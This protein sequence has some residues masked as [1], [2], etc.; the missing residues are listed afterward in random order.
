MIVYFHLILNIL[1]LDK[2]LIDN[3]DLDDYSLPFSLS[4]EKELDTVSD[5]IEYK[6]KL[7]RY[8]NRYSIFSKDKMF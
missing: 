1:H 6:N 4:N 5:E 7:F 3:L 8:K 2:N